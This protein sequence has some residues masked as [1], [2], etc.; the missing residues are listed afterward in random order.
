M[1]NL[2]STKIAMLEK[3]IAKGKWHY[4]T[5]YGVLGWGIS[6]SFLATFIQT[7]ISDSSFMEQISTALIIY[8]I[9]GL[10]LGLVMWM[11][12][13]NQYRKLISGKNEL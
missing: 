4:V 13:N 1:S 7:Y 8:P 3:L 11:M 12:L 6:V 9:S 2:K 5:I 10:A